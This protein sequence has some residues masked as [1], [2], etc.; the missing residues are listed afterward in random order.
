[1]AAGRPLLL[2]WAASARDNSAA[3]RV[4]RRTGPLPAH[5]AIGGIPHITGVPYLTDP[6]LLGVGHQ[7]AGYGPAGVLLGVHDRRPAVIYFGGT[8]RGNTHHHP[9]PPRRAER[10]RQLAQRTVQV[11]FPGW[12]VPAGHAVRP[13]AGEVL[14]QL[15][16]H[17]AVLLVGGP[18]R[19]VLHVLGRHLHRQLGVAGYLDQGAE[20]FGRGVDRVFQ[21]GRGTPAFRGALLEDANRVPVAVCQVLHVRF[22]QRA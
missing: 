1:M 7:P 4:E 18:V 13:A 15:G 10:R 21:V 16:G 22:L 20:E 6:V 2:C 19:A 9:A 14:G 5:V 12:R 17:V 3:R 8:V 11:R